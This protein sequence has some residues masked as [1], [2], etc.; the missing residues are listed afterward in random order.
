MV[1]NMLMAKIEKDM[2]ELQDRPKFGD[3]V[4]KKQATIH[5]FNGGPV[6]IRWA[7][8]ED[9]AIDQVFE[10]KTPKGE[11]LW[12]DW[13]EIMHYGRAIGSYRTQAWEDN[14]QR[15]IEKKALEG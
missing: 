12:L 15:L 5:N 10:L 8:N 2:S 14:Q 1:Y 3:V 9:V 6:K 13:Q 7:W 11:I 4:K